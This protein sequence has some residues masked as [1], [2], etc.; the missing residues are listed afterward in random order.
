MSRERR[1]LQDGNDRTATIARWLL[2]SPESESVVELVL[3]AWTGDDEPAVLARWVRSAVN[4]ELAPTISELIQD[5]ADDNGTT[6]TAQLTWTTQSGGPWTAKRFR[7][8]CSQAAVEV[9]RPLDGSSSAVLAQ[10]QRHNEILLQKMCE[11]VDRTDSRW[12]RIFERTDKQ[13]ERAERR[14][15]TAEDAVLE[16][17]QSASEAVEL[18]EQAATEAEAAVAAAEAAGADDKVAKVVEIAVKQLGG[19]ASQ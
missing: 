19:G 9:V 16:L 2:A 3:T 15:E 14:A 18:A 5:Y 1:G 13:L 10:M 6:C 17:E 11:L 8:R 4:R 12:E 7:G